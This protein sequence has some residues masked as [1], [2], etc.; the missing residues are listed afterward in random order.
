MNHLRKS[1]RIKVLQ[2]RLSDR[3]IDAAILIFSRDM[4][5]YTGTAQPCLLLVT[6]DDYRLLV[7]RALDFVEKETFL[8]KEKIKD[9]GNLHYALNSLGSLG[10]RRGKLGLE[11]DV[12]PAELYLKIK[13]IF[14]NYELTDISKN[15]LQ[16]RMQKD[17]EEITA[18]RQS[19]RIMD[20]GHQRVLETLHP[21]MTE[22]QLAAEVE[23]AH[24]REGHE[25]ILSM[26]HFDFYISRG[27][28][29]SGDNLFKVSGFANTITGIGLSSAVPAGPSATEINN[30]DLIIIDIPTCYKGYH[31]DQT[32]TYFLGDPPNEVKELFQKLRDISDQ[33]IMF[34][35]EGVTCREVFETAYST[36]KSLGV[37]EYFLGLQPRKGNFVGHG[38]G[39]DANEPPII[40]HNSDVQLLRNFVLTI[41]LHLTHPK[42]GAVKL[43]DVVLVKENGCDMLSITPR[44]LFLVKDRGRR[45][46]AGGDGDRIGIIGKH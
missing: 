22:I 9:K 39:L 16:Q 38:I 41:E 40:S 20:A 5:Y 8:E 24:R 46:E 44:E 2:K 10:V 32:R 11:L 1:N 25:G 18:I 13:N 36:S 31:C 12:I 23:Y 17:E 14:N 45:R 33:T 27:P 43:E 37:A 35:K 30:G 4:F 26:R 3:Q 21:G 42:H 6:P 7:K 34:L 28:L 29:S 19:C 15:I